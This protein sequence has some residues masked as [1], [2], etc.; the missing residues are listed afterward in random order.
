M[1]MIPTGVIDVVWEM[2]H[3]ITGEMV[4][5]SIQIINNKVIDPSEVVKHKDSFF[6]WD[7]KEFNPM[8]SPNEYW[9]M[10]WEEPL[11][12]LEKTCEELKIDLEKYNVK[13]VPLNLFEDIFKEE[14][15]EQ[16]LDYNYIK[17]PED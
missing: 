15:K 6:I 2:K 9:I 4:F 10:G 7:G 12:Q 3:E 1:D 17:E 11:N 5:I 16:G 13:L 14:A 8:K